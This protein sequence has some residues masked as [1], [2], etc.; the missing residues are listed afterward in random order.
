MVRDQFLVLHSLECNGVL[1]CE[2]VG[3]ETHLV[4]HKVINTTQLSFSTT[5]YCVRNTTVKLGMQGI[6]EDQNNHKDDVIFPSFSSHQKELIG[7]FFVIFENIPTGAAY[8]WGPTNLIWKFMRER[9][10]KIWWI[11]YHWIRL[12]NLRRL[13]LFSENLVKFDIFCRLCL[14]ATVGWLGG[15]FWDLNLNSNSQN[16]N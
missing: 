11:W 6:W 2:R 10:G 9:L 15:H 3:C 12:I 16:G 8:F 1:N 14:S 13:R 4:L 7:L 5:M